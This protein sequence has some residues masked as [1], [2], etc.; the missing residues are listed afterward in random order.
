MPEGRNL[1][2]YPLSSATADSESSCVPKSDSV[3]SRHSLLGLSS[4][5]VMKLP[6]T[7]PLPDWPSAIR[8]LDCSPPTLLQARSVGNTK[9][10]TTRLWDPERM[11]VWGGAMVCRT[12]LI[13]KA[14]RT[15]LLLLIPGAVVSA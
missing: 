8:P 9:K 2:R 6:P 12:K 3:S 5:E 7:E 1:G 13:L 10:V 11:V 14:N 4:R 15:D